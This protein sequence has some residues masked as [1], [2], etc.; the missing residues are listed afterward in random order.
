[1][2]WSMPFSW[3]A[4]PRRTVRRADMAMPTD[5]WTRH[6]TRAG[7][8]RHPGTRQR[9]GKPRRRLP[10]RTTQALYGV[11]PSFADMLPWVEYLP[12]PRAC[13]WRTANRW[14]PS[15]SWRRWAPRGARWPGCGRRAM[16][17]RTRCRT[18]S[19]NSTRTPGWSS[20][21]PGRIELGQLPARAGRATCGRAPRAAP[22]ATSTC[23]S[24]RITCA[25]SP[26]P[27]ACSRTRR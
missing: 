18:R 8:T 1:M 16:R 15:S 17:W 14:R 12:G 27:A 4:R 20:S 26:S 6:V 25:P 2:A 23:A 19:T 10:K 11:A 24:S 13:C 3:G 5:A 7:R 22:S 21:T 9:A